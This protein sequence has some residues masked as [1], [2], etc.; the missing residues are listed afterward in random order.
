MVVNF[1]KQELELRKQHLVKQ[2]NQFEVSLSELEVQL[3]ESLSK[4]NPETILDDTE[5]INNLDQM[6]KTSL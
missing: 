4:A 5:L 6:K 2:Q 3:L 1:E